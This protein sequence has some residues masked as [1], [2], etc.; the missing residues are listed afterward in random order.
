MNQSNHPC[1]LIVL[2]HTE[3]PIGVQRARERRQA[4]ETASRFLP[5]RATQLTRPATLDELVNRDAE[6]AVSLLWGRWELLGSLELFSLAFS[7][8]GIRRKQ[9]RGCGG[10]VRG[11]VST[12]FFF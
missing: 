7:F 2:T 12:F 10:G 5:S 6:T 1:S 11:L 9:R 8:H 3:H 4:V